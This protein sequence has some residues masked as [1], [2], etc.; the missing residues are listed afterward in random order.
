M[1]VNSLSQGLNI[2]LPKAGLETRTSRSESRASTIRPR[3]HTYMIQQLE[4][5][6]YP[7][8]LFTHLEEHVP[9]YSWSVV[10][11]TIGGQMGLF[12]GASVLTVVEFVELTVLAFVVLC[13]YG[14]SNLCNKLSPPPRGP[15]SPIQDDEAAWF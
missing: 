11:G 3:R 15:P 4:L 13:R 1:C 7:D 8:S 9:K 2:D 5:K 6:I 14:Y 10:F 12:T